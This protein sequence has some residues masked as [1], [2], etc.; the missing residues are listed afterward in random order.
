MSTSGSTTPPAQYHQHVPQPFILDPVPST[1]LRRHVYQVSRKWN[2][3]VPVALSLRG[4]MSLELGPVAE[5]T[6]HA[7]SDND[8]LR[9]LCTQK[10]PRRM[11]LDSSDEEFLLAICRAP[12]S[13][14]ARTTVTEAEPQQVQPDAATCATASARV[15]EYYRHASELSEAAESPAPACKRRE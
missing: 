8:F 11:E 6:G 4:I 3:D 9:D 1:V 14:A 2:T 10:R 12:R 15:P 13:A 5:G 7:D